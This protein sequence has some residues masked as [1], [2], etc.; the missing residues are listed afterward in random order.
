MSDV[1]W[2]V[3][4]PKY[5]DAVVPVKDEKAA[6]ELIVQYRQVTRHHRAQC[7]WEYGTHVP[8]TPNSYRRM[9]P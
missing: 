3:R 7:R 8:G 5:P 6:R 1:R 2:L 9:G 4:S